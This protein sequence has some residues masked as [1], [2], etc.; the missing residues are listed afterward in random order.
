MTRIDEISLSEHP[1]LSSPPPLSPT[2]S[3]CTA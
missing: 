1:G 2:R 3:S